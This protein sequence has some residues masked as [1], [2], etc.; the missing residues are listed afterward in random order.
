MKTYINTQLYTIEEALVKYVIFQVIE[1]LAKLSEI[2]SRMEMDKRLLMFDFEDND[3]EAMQFIDTIELQQYYIA[4]NIKT[5]TL[6]LEIQ[7]KQFLVKQA[8]L[9]LNLTIGLN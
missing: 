7:E 3:V 8:C 1:K 4:E 9:G 2:Y 5:L 6:V